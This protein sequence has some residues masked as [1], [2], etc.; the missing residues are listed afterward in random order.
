[1]YIHNCSLEEIH[2]VHVQLVHVQL[3]RVQHRLTC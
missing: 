2:L 1:M 3:V